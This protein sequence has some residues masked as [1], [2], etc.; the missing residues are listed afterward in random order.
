MM[1]SKSL[2]RI[3]MGWLILLSVCAFCFGQDHLDL[4]GQWAFE[5]DPNDMGIS[6]GWFD[7]SLAHSINLPGSLQEQDY[8]EK[9]SAKTK[10]TSGIGMGLL[11]DPRFAEYIHGEDFK[12]PFWLTPKRHYVG[13][14]WYQ[15]QVT[16]PADWADKRIML[17]LERPHWQTTVWVDGQKVGVRDSLGT[18]HEYDLT[19]VCRPG[20]CHRL[21]IR[22]DNRLIV[23]VGRDAHSISDQTQSN[24]N[25]ITGR[26][27]MIASPRVW[28]EDVQIYPDLADRQIK[29]VVKL[30]NSTA[31]AGSGQITVR[32]FSDKRH[33]TLPQHVAVNWTKQDGQLMLVHSMGRDCLLWDEYSP[34]L[35][36]LALN[37]KSTGLEAERIVTFGM[38]E[39]G[40][41]DKQ[42]TINGRKIFLRGT[43][44]CC[45][46]PQHG[47]PPTDVAEWKRIISI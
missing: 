14:A 31:K 16:I 40:I 23:P 30:G 44:E 11:D 29:V 39:L 6:G 37:L 20:Q 22:V 8:G 5:L 32:A 42:F 34:A 28:F 17:V 21:T 15:R 10:W 4:S 41:R 25:G 9:P 35:Y 7:K 13:A 18:A 36:K 43:L 2:P 1:K 47:Y 26:I 46:F 3:L 27:R 33:V 19:G 38:R 12:C 24:W 45:I